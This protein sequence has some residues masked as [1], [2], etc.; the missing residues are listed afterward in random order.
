MKI[1]KRILLTIVYIVLL[2]LLYA[3]IFALSAQDGGTSGELSMRFS[4][5]CTELLG[6]LSGKNWTDAIVGELAANFEHPLRKTAHFT[7]YAC[8]G[9][10]VY[11]LCC[12]WVQKR[13]LLYGIPVAWVFVSAGLDEFHQYFVPGRYASFLDVCL[14]TLGGAAGLL[15]AL[16]LQKLF[17]QLFRKKFHPKRKLR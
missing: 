5:K 10:L 14:D 17:R 3:A 2:A 7:E 4:G 15:L 13:K 12:L 6:S 11:L 8:M 9:A 1:N 16:L